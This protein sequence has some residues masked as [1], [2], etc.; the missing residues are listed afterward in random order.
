MYLQCK[1]RSRSLNIKWF[2]EILFVLSRSSEFK[3]SAW[4]SQHSSEM[5]LLGNSPSI[6][7]YK[8]L[9]RSY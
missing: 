4:S 8:F 1:Y 9:L 2:D 3:A 5:T 7:Y 6:L